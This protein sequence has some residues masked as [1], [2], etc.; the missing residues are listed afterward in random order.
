[1]LSNREALLHSQIIIS[2]LIRSILK[3]AKIPIEIAKLEGDAVFMY[4]LKRG[5]RSGTDS[6]QPTSFQDLGSKLLVFIASFMAKLKEL[7]RRSTCNCPACS[8]LDLLRLKIV[9]HSGEA[10]FYKLDRFEELSGLDVIIVHRL[11]KNSVMA[12]Q[13]ILLTTAAHQD[14]EF[15]K[16]IHFQPGVEEYDDV[17]LIETWLYELPEQPLSHEPS[18]HDQHLSSLVQ[19]EPWIN[20]VS[21]AFQTIN[22][23]QY[24]CWMMWRSLLLSL[25]LE[26][27]KRLSYLAPAQHWLQSGRSTWMVGMS[28]L[29][30]GISTALILG[31]IKLAFPVDPETLAQNYLDPETGFISG[32]FADQIV[33]RLGI[34]IS[35]FL[36]V[37]GWLEI[38]MAII[39]V[40]WGAHTPMLG[41][42]M[43]FMFWLF[44]IAHP[45]VGAISLSRDIALAGFCLAIT[46]TGPA[47]WDTQGNFQ[48]RDIVL[49]LLRLSLS[50]TL[51]M[52]ALFSQGVM[53]NPLNRT[54]P[55]NLVLGLGLALGMGFA[56]RIAGLFVAL[57]L[58]VFVGLSVVDIG[59]L[60]GGLEAVKREI[61]LM[62]GAAVFGLL[63]RDRWAWPKSPSK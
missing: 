43:G 55:V 10:L 3:E 52:S 44:T 2:E 7:D 31:G 16:T 14:L 4:C 29:R 56:T 30:W 18:A 60:Y 20:P 63:G 59:D 57:W 36:Q 6:S 19:S 17:G 50:Y 25:R 21:V 54:L 48:R 40:F 45:V 23:W 39:N 26:P 12:R 33:N 58:L 32:F 38:L 35:H 28:A 47:A 41:L 11:L 62:V 53:A 61:V 34:S 1:M 24:S 15:P 42:M 49:L 22:Q 8:N 51:I 46:L 13:Y 5:D 27:F 9:V 37:Q